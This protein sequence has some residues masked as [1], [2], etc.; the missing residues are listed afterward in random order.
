MFLLQIYLI[1]LILLTQGLVS[2]WGFVVNPCF[3]PCCIDQDDFAEAEL[4]E[5]PWRVPSMGA[6]PPGLPGKGTSGGGFCS[7]LHVGGAHPGELGDALLL[8]MTPTEY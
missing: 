1:V 6:G 2:S 4:S 5:P 8:G 7:A 3:Q